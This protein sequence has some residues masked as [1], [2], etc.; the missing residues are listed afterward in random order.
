MIWICNAWITCRLCS[1]HSDFIESLCN[2]YHTNN[3]LSRTIT[4]SM[5]WFTVDWQVQMYCWSYITV[6]SLT[7]FQ[8]LR[9]ETFLSKYYW[10][11][12]STLLNALMTIFKMVSQT[13]KSRKKGQKA[14]VHVQ[15]QS[16][17]SFEKELWEGK[18]VELE[19]DK[20]H[21]N[22]LSHRCTEH[23]ACSELNYFSLHLQSWRMI[24]YEC[25]AQEEGAS[26]WGFKQTIIQ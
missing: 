8:M 24:P 17:T 10:M 7:L 5:V 22:T 2:N 4:L 1:W 6:K 25:S 12:R 26:P 16:L 14:F 9:N 18:K 3:M 19:D 23:Q 13:H 11:N 15:K 21:E 20:P